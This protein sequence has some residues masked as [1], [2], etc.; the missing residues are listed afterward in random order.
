MSSKTENQARDQMVLHGHSLH[1]RG[2]VPGSSGNLSVRL[3]DGI[4]VTPTNS[5]LG[6][7]DPARISKLDLDGHHVTGDPPSKEGFLHLQMYRSRP[8]MK[9]VAHLH[10]TYAVALSCC[11][12]L[13]P[14]NV[15]PAM[16]PYQVMKTGEVPLL[17]YFPPGD[18][19][20]ANAVGTMAQAHH[21]ILLAN[22]GPVIG[23]K[24]LDIAVYAIEELEESARLHFVLEGRDTRPLN[25]SQVAELK[26]RFPS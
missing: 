15:L 20:L 8:E 23:G 21:A 7:L 22:H 17:P 26:R 5:C 13:N 4:L 11:D 24:N 1:A 19:G 25:A 9:A 12:G 14:K 3:S 6:R 10:S 16:T 18:P 2:Y